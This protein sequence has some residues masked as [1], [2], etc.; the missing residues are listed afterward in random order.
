MN[1]KTIAVAAA[2]TLIAC[3]PALAQE[4]GEVRA[5]P[6]TG[7]APVQMTLNLKPVRDGEASPKH[8]AVRE[9]ITGVSGS[10]SVKVVIANVGRKGIADR[11]DNFAMRDAKGEVPIKAEDDEPIPGG[12]AYYRH[13]RAQRPVSGK[14]TVTYQMRPQPKPSGGPQYEF[15]S[16]NGG[17][18]SAGEQIFVLPEDLKDVATKIHWDLS[19]LAPGSIAVSTLGRGDVEKR[20]PANDLRSGY[21]LVGPL[22]QYEAKHPGFE[23]YWLGH[24]AADPNKEMAWLED[25][26]DAMRGF[27]KDDKTKVYRVFIQ[28]TGNGGGSANANS[29]MGAWAPG[30][31]DP[32]KQGPRMNVFH[33]IDHYF[34]GGLT[35]AKEGGQGWYQEGANT[36][37]TRMLAYRAGLSPF[38]TYLGDINGYARAYYI[39]AYK[40]KT[41]EEKI[42]IGYSTGFGGD[43]AQNL[44]YSRGEFLWSEIDYRIRLAS[45]GKRKLDDVLVPLIVARRN[46]TPLTEARLWEALGPE[47]KGVY[48]AVVVRGETLVPSSG[49]FGPCLER[50]PK[51]YEARGEKFDGYEWVRVE[52]KTGEECRKW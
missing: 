42:K 6:P 23:A 36:F 5:K 47:A 20:G 4:D 43:G 19:D 13:W 21:Y 45:G 27:W 48:E 9:E 7:K 26:Y 41:A 35:G 39:S 46:G 12:Y 15:Y 18:N 29:F 33:E 8:L 1:F 50:K 25:G 3:A 17:L 51:V 31:E 34:V 2:L 32:T 40:N 14:V 30:N 11:V 37:Y 28:T 16:H 49:A 38:E 24:P 22:G 52:G 44:D 10:F